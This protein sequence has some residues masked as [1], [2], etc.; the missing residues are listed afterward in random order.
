MKRVLIGIVAL[1]VAWAAATAAALEAREILAET[2]VRGGLVAHVG[3]G[4]GTLTAALRANERYLVHGLDADAALVKKARAHVRSVG[5]YGPVSV[6]RWSGARLPYTDNL[7]NLLVVEDADAVPAAEIERV[8]CPGGVAYVKKAGGWAKTVASG[9]ENIDEWTH[10]LH[11]PDNNAVA[12]DT[13]VGP[14]HHLQ[15]VGGPKWCRSHDHLSSVSAAVS[16]GGRLFY[17]ADEAPAATVAFP[18]AWHLIARDAFSGVVLWKQPIGPWV[19]QFRGFRTGPS[20]LARRLV[21]IDDRVYVTPGYGK[22]VVCLDAATGEV[23][24]RYQG[25]DNTRE[26]VCADGVLYLVVAAAAFDTKPDGS[27]APRDGR[28]ARPR[29]RHGRFPVV[30]PKKYL[31]A[32]DAKTG[33]RLWRK[34]DA[35]TVDLM[36]NGLAV[37]G[38]RVFL[39]SPEHVI[40]LR[41]TDGVELWRAKRPVQRHR[42]AW[43]APTLVVHGDVVLSA[44]RATP[45]AGKRKPG[46]E[47]G[48]VRWV[49]SSAGGQAPPGEL[50]AFSVKDGRELWSS[51]CR[52]VYN[53]P[54]DVLVTDGLVWT[55][56]MVRAN[57]K[58]IT[59]G[60]DPMTG[61]VKRTRPPDKKFFRVGMGHHRCHRNRATSRYL[62]LGRAGVEF[63][64]VKSGEG[65]AHHFVRGACQYGVLPCNGLLYAP[66]HSCA[67]YIRSKLS[68]FN[69]L[70]PKRAG[71]KPGEPPVE[72]GPAFG[73]VNAEA[74]AA[75]GADWPTYRHDPARSGRTTAP[76]PRSLEAGWQTKL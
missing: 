15:W 25:T 63:I 3:C 56:D 18:A 20:A 33:G 59:A 60:L 47:P 36:P 16:S 7:V 27:P 24:G 51:K 68:G 11:G 41:A 65:I 22:P 54:V 26:I 70:A 53:A 29:G 73:K 72:K 67:C 2:G 17:I 69:A 23:V 35:D 34:A 9:P 4:D 1:L 57:D 30:P 64:D 76:S 45:E 49:V 66:P 21:A 6:E 40:C 13:V 50:I 5:L 38:G 62:V 19:D 61:E 44:D 71:V 32:V 8:L 39:Q 31:M 10:A 37:S 42:P 52:E 28:P 12:D 58:G 74:P 48:R 75:D 46:E 55:G 14:P 43:S